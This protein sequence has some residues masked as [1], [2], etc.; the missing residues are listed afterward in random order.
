MSS[1]PL[2]ALSIRP[3]EQP[4]NPLD[5]YGKA[6]QL[7]NLAAQQQMIPGQLQLQQQQLQSGQLDI[8][9]TQQA[10][11]DEKAGHFSFAAMGWQRP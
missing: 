7:K 6:M 10:L 2:A 1:V 4:A 9:K 5:Q 11:T 3:P 8:Q